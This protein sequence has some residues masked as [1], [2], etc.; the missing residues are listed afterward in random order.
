MGK[1]V[2]RGCMHTGARMYVY[3]GEN[4]ATAERVDS[5]W[6]INYD[7]AAGDLDFFLEIRVAL[8]LYCFERKILK[9]ELNALRYS[10]FFTVS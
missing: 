10:C 5:S 7:L 1:Y 8:A 3:I 4:K 9:V 2:A 6:K